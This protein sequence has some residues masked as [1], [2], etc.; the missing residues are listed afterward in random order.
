MAAVNV[1]R[2]LDDRGM[3]VTLLGRGTLARL[4]RSAFFVTVCVLFLTA[5]Q[6]RAAPERRVAL[7]IGNSEYKDRSLVLANPKNDAS[8]VAEVLRSLGFEVQLQLNTGKR[9]LDAVFEKFARLAATADSALFFYAGH[10]IQYSGKNFLMPVDAEL[11]DEFSVRYNLVS[12]EDARSALDR[13]SGVKIM[14]LDA[15]RNNPIAD[16][17]NRLATGGQSRGI[18]P[19]TRGLARIDKTQG[20]VIAFATAPDDVALDGNNTRNSPFTSAL[21]KEMQVPGLEIGQMFRRVARDV[22]DATGGRQRP[23]TS[24]SLLSDYF[25]NQ[26]D[27]KIWEGMRDTADIAQIQEF[28]RRY[29]NSVSAVDAKYRLD[30]L[31]RAKR[32]REDE[33]AATQR[34]NYRKELAEQVAK[35]QADIA[36]LQESKKQAELLAA[37]Q[38][39][40]RQQAE[41]AQLAALEQKRKEE[42]QAAADRAKQ[43]KQAEE[44]RLAKL[45]QDRQDAAKASQEKHETEQRWQAAEKLAKIEEERVKAEQEAAEREKARRKEQEAAQKAAEVC[46]AE[47]AN[48]DLMND[49]IKLTL[50]T[51]NA[52]CADAR[53]RAQSKLASLQA[54]R[55][56]KRLEEQR[57][58]LELALK[59]K[60]LKLQSDREQ[61]EQHIAIENARLPPLATETKTTSMTARQRTSCQELNTRAQ[62]GDIT[63]ADRSALRLCH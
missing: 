35:M 39:S 60:L 7:V 56:K 44:Q 50:F 8:D 10:A 26:A 40:Q 17:L 63:E 62:L 5:D 6:A 57:A 22:S 30:L 28:L 53:L 27:R 49:E 14:I 19:T 52:V 54:D 34:E 13:A 33:Q 37:Q 21:I 29:P 51:A 1:G 36:K 15:C 2:D 48:V 25:L 9:E 46:K 20:M 45:E 3:R 58:S 41:K 47:Q 4:L 16:R 32:E 59:E 11:E 55:E 12:L 24:I 23:E 42:E 38:E 43:Q 18:G 61:A 31:E